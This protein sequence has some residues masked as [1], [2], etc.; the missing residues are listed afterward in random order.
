MGKPRSLA[1]Q[2][3]ARARDVF[4][5][6][7]GGDARGLGDR[8]DGPRLP[9][10]TNPLD[11]LGV[12][13]DQIPQPQPCHSVELGERG[14][15]GHMVRTRGACGHAPFAGV[16]RKSEEALVHDEQRAHLLAAASRG[17]DHA[18]V[19]EA[20]RRVVRIAEVRH[21][22]RP[23]DR[24]GEGGGHVEVV[25]FGERELLHACAV[26]RC[27]LRIFRERRRAHDDAFRAHRRGE[28]PDDV[29]RARAADDSIFGN[30]MGAR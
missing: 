1:R 6:F 5:V 26:V 3:I 8:G 10:P 29:G 21:V 20:P 11:E 30:A 2:Y 7:Q 12:S 13:A 18:G 4:D 16:G 22:S 14:E 24:A 19:D 23:L 15:H 28:P 25:R 9:R 27:R 17:I